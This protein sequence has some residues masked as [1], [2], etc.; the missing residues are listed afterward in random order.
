MIVFTIGI[1]ELN[2]LHK[3]VKIFECTINLHYKL[4]LFLKKSEFSE[5]RERERETSVA[6]VHWKCFHEI[7][8]DKQ[9]KIFERSDSSSS[10]G[11]TVQFE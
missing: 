7:E 11:I 1:F 8:S 4:S 5:Q 6:Q 9:C 2:I 10:G 3:T